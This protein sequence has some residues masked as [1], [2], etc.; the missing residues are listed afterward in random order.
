[1]TNSR[2]LLN[3]LLIRSAAMNLDQ[4]AMYRRLGE[5]RAAR[6]CIKWA[7]EDRTMNYGDEK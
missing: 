7:R 5:Y 4:A 6:R 1:M 2:M 3:R